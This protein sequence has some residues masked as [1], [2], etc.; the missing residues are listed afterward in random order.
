M[1][2]LQALFPERVPALLLDPTPLTLPDWFRRPEFQVPLGFGVLLLLVLFFLKFPDLMSWWRSRHKE[3]LDPVQLDQIMMGTPMA[4]I[5]LRPPE[6]FNGP[7]GHLKGS[8]NI[9]VQMLTRR[10]GEVAKDKRHLVVLVDGSDKRSHLAAPLLKA[11]GYLWVRVLQ[12][13]VRAW[14][15]KDLPVNIA[16]GR[17]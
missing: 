6:E 3:V 11:E 13:G 2:I 8:I 17:S 14:R 12:G 10:I 15:A 4:I 5:D 1:S 7:K 9:P 16:G